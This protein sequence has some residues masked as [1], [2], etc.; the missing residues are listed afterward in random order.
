MLGIGSNFH[1]LFLAG[2]GTRGYQDLGLL[3]LVTIT[4]S[5]EPFSSPNSADPADLPTL[6]TAY[7]V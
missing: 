2:F 5:G 4:L 1:R 7:G 6:D 3:Y